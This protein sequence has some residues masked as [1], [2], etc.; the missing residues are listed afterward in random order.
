LS[1]F[2]RLLEGRSPPDRR[3]VPCDRRHGNG[4]VGLSAQVVGL[5]AQVSV[6]DQAPGGGRLLAAGCRQERVRRR[7]CLWRRKA[8]AAIAGATSEATKKGGPE[9]QGVAANHATSGTVPRR[10]TI[11]RPRC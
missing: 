7:S 4:C 2:V 5:S 9:F 6:R 1:P 8:A 11:A 10:T 3:W